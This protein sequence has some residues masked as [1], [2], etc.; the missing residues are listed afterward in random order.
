M[1]TKNSKPERDNVANNDQLQDQVI[2]EVDGDPI[3][4]AQEEEGDDENE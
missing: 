3:F 2:N 4:H 1:T